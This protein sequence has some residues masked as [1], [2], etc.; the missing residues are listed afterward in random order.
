MLNRDQPPA[1]RVEKVT[2][3]EMRLAL[4]GDWT[5]AH[6]APDPEAF[7]DLLTRE[8]PDTI[9]F[10]TADLNK[11]DSLLPVY[12][13]RLVQLCEP[14]QIRV[15]FEGLPAGTQKLLQLSRAASPKSET[16]QPKPGF[17]TG[18]GLKS[19]ELFDR[20]EELISFSGEILIACLQ[21]VSGRDKFRFNDFW[22]YVQAT[23]A[24]ALPIVSLISV[25]VGVILAFVGAVQ[26]QMFG[27]QIYIANLVGLAMVMEMGAM[28]SGV[29]MAG[30]TG[31][32]YAAQLG[33]MQV[34]EEIDALRTLGISPVAF[35]VLPRMFALMFM[36][37]L[38]CIYADILGIAGGAIIGVCMLDLSLVEYF[39]YTRQAIHLEQCMQG[40]VKSAV[41][42]VLVG[43]AGCLR[44]LQCGR[45]ASSVGEAA[46]SAV[47]TGIVLIVIADAVMTF[48]FNFSQVR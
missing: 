48:L 32:A 3:K 41:Y 46:T 18:L 45:S 29:I 44:G 12:I 26:L 37:P 11:W 6:P 16:E 39:D 28:M 31:A 20:G 15:N 27:A 47:V 33:S 8:K 19:I 42:G 34:N 21:V 2:A 9:S 25:L 14:L 23:G 35:L 24:E 17:F 38:L 43:Y 22:G 5:L 30:R 1:Y 13:L 7:R 36:L 4:L 10:D 40:L